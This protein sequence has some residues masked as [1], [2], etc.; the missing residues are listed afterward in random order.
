MATKAQ[1]E[2]REREIVS[3]CLCGV[4]LKRT[5]GQGTVWGPGVQEFK[6]LN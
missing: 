1:E 6:K 3:V 2:E 5:Y 4:M